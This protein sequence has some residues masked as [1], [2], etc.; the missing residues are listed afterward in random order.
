M[1]NYKPTTRMYDVGLAAALETYGFHVITARIDFN[2]S[3]YF[4]VVRSLG[5]DKAIN[6]YEANHMS[7]RAKTFSE[8]ITLLVNRAQ[9]NL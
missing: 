2:G 1:V 4:E 3:M 7:V 6:A 5:V 8:N 9:A